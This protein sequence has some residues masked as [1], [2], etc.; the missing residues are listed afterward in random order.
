[1]EIPL[2]RLAMLVTASCQLAGGAEP[3]SWQLAVTSTGQPL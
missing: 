3:A 2:P 1:M